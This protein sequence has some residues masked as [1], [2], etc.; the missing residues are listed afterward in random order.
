[1]DMKTDAI[2]SIQQVSNGDGE[3]YYCPMHCEGEK[4]YDKPGNCPV[5]GM[6]LKKVSSDEKQNS[7]KIHA[8]DTGD[9]YYCPMHCEGDKVYDKAGNCPVCGMNLVKVPTVPKENSTRQ[10]T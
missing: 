1:M 4:A 9:K 3:K 7:I 2:T 10:I 6:N 8:A 5:C